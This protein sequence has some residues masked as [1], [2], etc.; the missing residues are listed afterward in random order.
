[1]KETAGVVILSATDLE[2]LHFGGEGLDGC[3]HGAVGGC[4]RQWGIPR[5]LARR[6]DYSLLSTC[7][8]ESEVCE[9]FGSNVLVDGCFRLP[10]FPSAGEECE[11][12]GG[13]SR[14]FLTFFTWFV[15]VKN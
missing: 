4:R 9:V 11:E 3:G 6:F 5:L 14:V 10:H 12:S 7:G 15:W 13:G 2:C 1:V 8:E